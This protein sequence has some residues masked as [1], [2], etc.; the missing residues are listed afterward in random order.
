VQLVWLEP[1]LIN[2]LANPVWLQFLSHKLGRL[3][4]PY[5][6]VVLLVASGALAR[7]SAFFAVVFGAQLLFYGL[8]TYGGYLEYRDR[9]AKGGA[10]VE[11]T[12]LSSTRTI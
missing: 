6:L 3:V 10:A 5:A 11:P 2:P 9:Q 8:A 12:A 7:Q 4:V 1:R